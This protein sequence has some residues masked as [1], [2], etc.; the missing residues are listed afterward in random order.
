MH[1]IKAQIDVP[2]NKYKAGKEGKDVNAKSI[3][4]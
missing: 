3:V 4:N 1:L 2:N